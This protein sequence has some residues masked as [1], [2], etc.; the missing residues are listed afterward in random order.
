ME[1]LIDI[2]DFFNQYG[3]LTNEEWNKVISIV[4]HVSLNKGDFFIKANEVKD[5]L[6]FIVKGCMRYY[7][8]KDGEEITGEFWQEN[9]LVASY[10]GCILNKPSTLYIEAIEDTSLVILSYNQLKK[11]SAEILELD[12]IIITL[13]EKF[14]VESQL[15]IASYITEKA[16]ER[17]LRLRE[18]MPGIEDRVHQKYIASFVGVTPVTLSRIRA[19]LAKK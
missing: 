6:G 17:Y 3:K 12:K 2:K 19:R 8:I 9:E 10:E 11:L 7:Y 1:L 13:L 4:R 14:I 16:E 18:E 15:R 5:Q